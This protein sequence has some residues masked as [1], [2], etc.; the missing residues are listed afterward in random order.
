MSDDRT[1]GLDEDAR[2]VQV[3]AYPL[4][5]AQRVRL[6]FTQPLDPT[7]ARPLN[8]AGAPLNTLGHQRRLSDPTLTVG[9]APNVDTLYSVAWLDV[10]HNSFTLRFPDFGTRYASFQVALPDTSTPIT[11]SAPAQGQRLP[12]VS[13]TRGPARCEV[14][15]DEVRLHT[16]WR[17][18]M[19]VGRILVEPEESG[20]DL[21]TV[22]RL[23]D[24]IELQ[25]LPVDDVHPNA[26]DDLELARLSRE[27]ETTDP[28]AF[29]RALQQV[30]VD[31]APAVVDVPL[32]RALTR[33]LDNSS[34]LEVA[35]GLRRGLQDIADHVRR[36][37][38]P[39]NGWAIND[40]GTDFGTDHLLRAAVA[41]SQIFIN[42][43][44]EA[45]YPVCEVDSNGDLLDGGASDYR[46]TFETGSLPP[47]DAFWSLTAY[48]AKGLLVDNEI[49]RYAIGDRTPGLAYG[50]DGSL[51]IKISTARPEAT[52]NWL[53]VPAGPFR[54]MLRLYRPTT[55][56]W[57][58]PPVV[59]TPLRSMP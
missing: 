29:T 1:T 44:S 37:G 40:T 23:Q 13:I 3:W 52:A 38:R 20:D 35:D 14:T 55:T 51:T 25:R 41:H 7:A 24:S 16:P 48:H 9:V 47:V 4:V 50:R 56:K 21:A 45:L 32:R 31:A 49:G 22:H 43:A 46:L 33:V 8:S 15:D 5:F 12:A 53:P 28:D 27:D 42:P 34:P 59:P 19:V 11:I 10:Q 58:P 54:L 57:D 17:Y 30:L 18:A 2:A 6:N 36:L 26:A 39:A